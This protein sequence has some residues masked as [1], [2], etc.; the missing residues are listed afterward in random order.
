VLVVDVQTIPGRQVVLVLV[1]LVLGGIHGP[2]G[3][4]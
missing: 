1:V 4:G 2:P 3:K